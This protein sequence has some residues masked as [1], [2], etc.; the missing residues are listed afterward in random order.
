[1]RLFIFIK[2]FVW[3]IREKLRVTSSKSFSK[4]SKDYACVLK[5]WLQR[6][7][8]LTFVRKHTI[9]IVCCW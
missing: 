6:Y 2:R 5:N 8:L 7:S 9:Q 4:L 3:F 1:M